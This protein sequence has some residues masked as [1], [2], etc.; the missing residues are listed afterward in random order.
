MARELIKT[1][2]SNMSEPEFKTMI[3][4]ILAGIEKSMEDIKESLTAEIKDLRTSQVEVKNA[5]T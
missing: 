5:I 4:K 3:I 2:I 1:G